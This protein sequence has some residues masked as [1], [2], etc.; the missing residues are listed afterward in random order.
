MKHLRKPKK[1]PQ[2]SAFKPLK[3]LLNIIRM[4]VDDKAFITHDAGHPVIKYRL[5]DGV[6]VS[7]VRHILTESE[8]I[9]ICKDL[10]VL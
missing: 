9:R 8:A 2:H 4:Y 6:C 3:H 5:H 10:G 7:F 1:Q